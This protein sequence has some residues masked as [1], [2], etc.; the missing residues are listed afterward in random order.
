VHFGYW[1]LSFLPGVLAA[2]FLCDYS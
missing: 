2:G 1:K